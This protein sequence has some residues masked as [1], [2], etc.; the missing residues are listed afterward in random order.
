MQNSYHQQYEAGPYPGKEHVDLHD[1]PLGFNATDIPLSEE[2][3]RGSGPK[4]S[5]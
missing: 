1:L 3:L 2:R 5:A 4:I